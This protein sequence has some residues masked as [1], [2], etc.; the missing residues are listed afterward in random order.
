MKTLTVILGILLF[1]MIGCKP[2]EDPCKANEKEY[3]ENPTVIIQ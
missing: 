2:A 3:K 1:V